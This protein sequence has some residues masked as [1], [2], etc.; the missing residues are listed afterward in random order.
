MET[1][2]P[3]PDTFRRWIVVA[4]MLGAALVAIVPSVN[5]CHEPDDCDPHGP[6]DC[7]GSE[8]YP[9]DG[10]GDYGGNY[11][12]CYEDSTGSEVCDE[13]HCEWHHG[14]RWCNYRGT[15]CVGT[16]D[17]E[18]QSSPDEPEAFEDVRRALFDR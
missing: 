10:Q 15:S 11:R 8:E 17:D 1:T 7:P 12:C 6:R 5:A 14:R 18:D 3:S 4:L 9:D 2:R 13:W 16:A